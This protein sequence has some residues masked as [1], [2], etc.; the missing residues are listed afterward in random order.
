MSP[1]DVVLDD[2]INNVKCKGIAL[3]ARDGSTLSSSLGDG[4]SIDTFSIMSA[5]MMGAADTASRE[6]GQ[7]SMKRVTVKNEDGS[8]LIYPVGKRNLLVLVFDTEPDG[9]DEVVGPQMDMLASF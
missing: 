8:V 2:I 7:R 6:V 1:G 3:V 5:T 4:V 9:V